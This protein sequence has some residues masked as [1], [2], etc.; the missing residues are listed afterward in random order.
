MSYIIYI[1][2][3]YFGSFLALFLYPPLVTYHAQS[4]YL[5]CHCRYFNR[6]SLVWHQVFIHQRDLRNP[7]VLPHC[8][9]FVSIVVRVS[10]FCVPRLHQT[11]HYYNA[12]DHEFKY[13]SEHVVFHCYVSHSREY[14][15]L[16]RWN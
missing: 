6:S 3:G 11:P 16:S 5:Q 4:L 12:Y 2:F 7:Q 14:S 15:P 13:S 1:Y 8:I 9:D 10:Y